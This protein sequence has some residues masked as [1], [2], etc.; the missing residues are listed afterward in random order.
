M[1]GV[2]LEYLSFPAC[3]LDLKGIIRNTNHAFAELAGFGQSDVFV[4]LPF[5]ELM[6]G[7][8][9]GQF[10]EFLKRC[11]HTD[12]VI[13]GSFT[14]CFPDVFG[15]RRRVIVNVKCSGDDDGIFLHLGHGSDYS[16]EAGLGSSFC[17][18]MEIFLEDEGLNSGY[19][20]I[21][22]FL[23]DESNMEGG[24]VYSMNPGPGENSPVMNTS[25][26]LFPR[27]ESVLQKRSILQRG[28]PRKVL[29][30]G[31]RLEDVTI[32]P[33]LRK[34]GIKTAV[35]LPV[36]SVG[37][38]QI[39][40]VLFSRT[41]KAFQSYEE[42]A[43]N[44]AYENII[45]VT[46]RLL[47]DQ[48]LMDSEKLYRSLIRSMPSGLI[49]RDRSGAIVHY[50]LAAAAIFGWK[51]DEGVSSENLMEDACFYNEEG[52]L[53]VADQLPGMLSLTRGEQIRNREIQV[54]R[55]DGSVIWLS[56]NSEPLVHAGD[57]EPFA[58][59]VT[60]KDISEN[61]KALEELQEARRRAEESGRTKNQFLANFSHEIRT[62]LSGIMGMTDILLM[63]DLT[64]E[65]QE[66]LFLMKDAEELLLDII[67]KVL[68]LSKLES[69]KLKVKTGI[70]H[71]EQTLKKAVSPVLAGARK[72]SCKISIEISEKIPDYLVG[73]AAHI[74][75][76]I[77]N[78]VE[79]AVKFVGSGVITLSVQ[80]YGNILQDVVPLLF[81]ISDTG[82]GIP[83]EEQEGIFENFRQV[84]SSFSKEHQGTG[85]GLSISKQLIEQ[86]GGSIWLVSEPGEGSTFFFNLELNR[87]EE[88]R[89]GFST[90]SG[91][92]TSPVADAEVLE[93]TDLSILLV[94][95]NPLNQEALSL[96]M[97]R[98]GYKVEVAADGVEA[99]EMLSSGSYELILMD[100]QMPK[101]N[102]IETT[103][104][105][106][107]GSVAG[108]DPIV[109]IIAL[110]AYAMSEEIKTIMDSGMNGYISKRVDK[111]E[112]FATIEEVLSRKGKT[113]RGI[114]S[115]EEEE[116]N[117]DTTVNTKTE[118]TDFQSF[119]E[120]YR[121]DIDVA[122]QLLWLFSRDVPI[123]ISSIEEALAHKD[124]K[125]LVDNFH[126]LTNNL[127]A[128]RLFS[129]GQVSRDLE[130]EAVQGNLEAI[131]EKFPNF[132]DELK[133]SLKHS[134]KYLRIL[135]IGT[136]K[137]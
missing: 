115:E 39:L 84:D 125:T 28:T 134:R 117:V 116:G 35:L 48:A 85:L 127:S 78:I 101:M 21:L 90:P 135:E 99:L 126:S 24:V 128:V 112:F 7:G 109:P 72:D 20:R 56:V 54:R 124:A 57:E 132:R 67:N 96:M 34:A 31:C 77:A 38:P 69:G 92:S 8:E 108:I 131:C 45:K 74:Q 62:P 102:G 91:V 76:V 49:V 37:K 121:S 79:N 61:R 10:E 66:Q 51:T 25:I 107:D 6:Q 3:V 13:D 43:L 40:Y 53:E 73:D 106:R 4:G 95:D 29:F 71:L 9:R 75:L 36:V 58:A 52:K 80:M 104:R 118:K 22:R 44:T 2:P 27:L 83:R 105:I 1:Y 82:R 14:T 133:D 12:H 15:E 122:R 55:R 137:K 59:I 30:F 18:L 100:I 19:N 129:L 136:F 17:R 70:F 119:V 26:G 130:K 111:T 41:K 46:K 89:Q 60:F 113:S 68:D 110:T 63:G 81:S 5:G 94:E 97:R 33:M 11:S 32:P 123:R 103:R 120:D 98:R 42:K 50:N 64:G 47:R 86:M 87:A 65:Q 23:L 16:G 88:S 114:R 93:T